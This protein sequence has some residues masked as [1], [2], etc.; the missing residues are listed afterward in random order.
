[1]VLVGFFF[2]SCV[3]S[4]VVRFNT[5]VDGAEIMVDGFKIGTTPTQYKMSNGFWEDPDVSIKKEGFKDLNFGVKKEVKVFNVVTG[6]V[7][8]PFTLCIPLLW[9]YGPKTNQNYVMIPETQ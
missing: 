2:S 3:T 5:D 7:L 9:S 1:M 8:S 6:V 4:T